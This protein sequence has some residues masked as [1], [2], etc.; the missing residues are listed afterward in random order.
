MWMNERARL[1][2]S[3]QM[4]SWINWII[5]TDTV[6]HLRSD[7]TYTPSFGVLLKNFTDEMSSVEVHFEGRVL[8]QRVGCWW[9]MLVLFFIII[10]SRHGGVFV[11]FTVWHEYK[12]SYWAVLVDVW[13]AEQIQKCKMDFLHHLAPNVGDADWTGHRRIYQEKKNILGK[14]YMPIYCRLFTSAF[15]T[16]HIEML[17]IYTKTAHAPGEASM[18]LSC[19]VRE[20]ETRRNSPPLRCPAGGEAGGGSHVWKNIPLI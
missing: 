3:T 17:C 12:R 14:M 4:R 20:A 1:G 10:L 19:R 15:N 8:P 9:F 2:V 16:A 6:F 7:V 13:G 11:W 18:E 5:T